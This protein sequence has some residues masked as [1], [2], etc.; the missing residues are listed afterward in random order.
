MNALASRRLPG[1]T[2]T[3]CLLGLVAFLALE[4]LLL[5]H[6]VRVDTRPPAWDQ[7]THLEIAL[8]YR[9]AMA[10]G[11]WGDLWYLPPKPGM[12]PFPPAYQLLLS[13]AYGSADPAHAAL[14][15]NWLYLA[16]LAASLF[17]LCWR[18]LPDSR[19]LAATLA[20]CAAPGLQDL[21]TTPLV[22]LSV[23]A[24]AAAGYWAL[25]ASE[26]FTAWVP[27]LLFGVLHAAGMMHKWSYFSYMLPAYLVAARA[28]GDRRSWRQVLAAALLSA[29]LSAPWYWAHLAILPARLV[30]ASSDFAVPFWKGRAWA[31]YLVQGGGSL[32]PPLLALGLIALPL[33]RYDRRNHQAWVIALWAAS[34]YAFWMVVPNR[35]IRFLLPGLAPLAL[36]AA[37]AWPRALT[38]LLAIVQ[39]AGAVNFFLGVVGPLRVATPLAPLVFLE[40]APPR[41][42]DWKIEE[43]L[44]RVEADRDPTRAITNV[45]LIANDARFNGP[46]FHWA[47]RRLG[48]PHV[49]MRGVNKRLCEL[50]EFVLLKTG[51]LGP[52]TVIGGLPEAARVV[53]EPRGWFQTAYAEDARWPLPD[54][55]A[56]VLYRQRRGRARP[57]ARARLGYMVFRV[58]HVEADGLRADF[59]PWDAARSAW[60]RA[61]LSAE[62]LDARGLSVRD[63][64]AE[65]ENFSL[66]PVYDGGG[67][68]D[69]GWSDVRVMRLDRVVVGGLR[70]DAADLKVFLEKRVPGLTIARL[71]LD[72]TIKTEGRWRGRPVSAEAALDLD[73][74][75][76]RLRVR[77]LSA[78]VLDVPI[79]PALFRPIKELNLSLDPNPETP[80]AIDL[81]GL[82]VKGGRLTVP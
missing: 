42:E 46:T 53:A 7:A 50:S 26:G 60:G 22:D 9:E 74:A 25:L 54:G 36:A 69:Y 67:S 8:D 34:S 65:L 77:V 23:V 4:A 71:T 47:Q 57:L 63:V 62:R 76:R 35:Q 72:G 30:Q 79:P 59:G 49:R 31:E 12:P 27:A 80:F 64:S 51:R 44:R 55:G 43:I 37:G 40:N 56:A 28:F 29:A 75:A 13:R 66:V 61:R 14:W 10:A 16:L 3:L 11:R 33:A 20:F 1:R 58:G 18:F 52:A 70:V 21:L 15:A 38:W 39:L 82:T 73:R 19:A 2:L 78:S 32:G 48:L 5:R 81:P 17:G 41:R 24:W 45:T 6:Y 68:G